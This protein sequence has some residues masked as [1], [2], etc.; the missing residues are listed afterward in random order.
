MTQVED[1]WQYSLQSRYVCQ[2][3]LALAVQCLLSSLRLGRLWASF[4]KQGPTELF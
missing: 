4:T 3:Y 1:R 2:S